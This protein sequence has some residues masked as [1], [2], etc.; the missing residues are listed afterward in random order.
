MS[1]ETGAIQTRP[2]PTKKSK[3]LPSLDEALNSKEDVWGLAAMRQSNG[4]S[5]EFFK[6]LLPP[7]RY[8]NAAFR[9]YPIILSGPGSPQKARLV[10]NGSTL[11]PRA[12]LATW[13]ESGIPITFLVGDGTNVFGEDLR[14][15]H[16]PVYAQGYLP[17]VQLSYEQGG[18][19]YEEETFASIEPGADAYGIA[20]TEFKVTEGRDGTISAQIE[21]KSPLTI[22]EGC[23][24]NRSGEALVKFGEKWKWDGVRQTLTALLR[25][26]KTRRPDGG[27]Q[28]DCAR[29]RAQ[30]ED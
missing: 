9:Y 30:V 4:P 15:L 1:A 12:N 11:N 14:K 20:F 7:L 24:C 27:D 6:D 10:S 18:A 29:N 21:S 22:R 28:T 3:P 2:L 26:G 19:V 17:I 13:K 25:K 16:G 8:V 23:V 5:Y